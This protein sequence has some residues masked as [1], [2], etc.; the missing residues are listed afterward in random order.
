M[1]FRT[2]AKIRQAARTRKTDPGAR[3]YL[4]CFFLTI[5]SILNVFIAL[6]ISVL[7]IYAG[8]APTMMEDY[9][10]FSVN[11]SRFGEN[12]IRELE[13]RIAPNLDL[14]RSEPQ[15]A[16]FPVAALTAPPT[17]LTTMAPRDISS[18]L[19]SLKD[20]AGSQVTSAVSGVYS[21]ATSAASG[22]QDTVT[23]VKSDLG[24]AVTSAASGV[25]DAVTSNQA[26][27]G[28]YVAGVYG[29]LQTDLA[30]A[31]DVAYAEVLDSMNI[32]DFYNVY[33]STT[34]SGTYIMPNGTNV[35][36][37]YM[38]PSPPNGTIKHIDVCNKHTGLDPLV[39]LPYLYWLGVIC[40]IIALYHAFM[41]IFLTSGKV[42]FLNVM[43]TF[44]AFG[45]IL[46]ASA[47]SSG[48][49]LGATRKFVTVVGMET[50]FSTVGGKFSL[51]T[52]SATFFLTSNMFIWSI[53]LLSLIHI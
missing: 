22:V 34:C 35:T 1:Q 15:L 6:L 11:M 47:V 44:P 27:V 46:A 28:S 39:Y 20:Q 51:L 52:W 42:A 31:I 49:A 33:V 30:S 14:K 45:F 19:G 2:F 48:I 18:D 26:S 32:S 3:T 9:A 29:A 50:G 16:H 8:T 37:G 24:S 53:I 4:K 21:V 10:I 40:T 41:G 13:S 7:C 5:A 17:T 43:A 36:V 25:H 23:S 12:V 38:G